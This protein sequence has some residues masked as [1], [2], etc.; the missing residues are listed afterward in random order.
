[1]AQT[2][3]I[4]RKGQQQAHYAEG[5]LLIYLLAAGLA[6]SGLGVD[7]RYL[8]SACLCYP[9]ESFSS[10]RGFP[11]SPKFAGVSGCVFCCLLIT[12]A[13]HSPPCRLALSW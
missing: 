11:P 3:K 10:P 1:M 9:L 5:T 13:R 12:P 2:Q 8:G 6:P 7:T 4:A